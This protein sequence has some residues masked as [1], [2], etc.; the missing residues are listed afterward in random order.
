MTRLYLE[1]S[2]RSHHPLVDLTDVNLNDYGFY[3]PAGI[4]VRSPL[5]PGRRTDFI[6]FIQKAE[7]FVIPPSQSLVIQNYPRGINWICADPF[8]GRMIGV[9]IDANRRKKTI[10]IENTGGRSVYIDGS[11]QPDNIPY[12]LDRKDVRPIRRIHNAAVVSATVLGLDIVKANLNMSHL[13]AFASRL[14]RS[15]A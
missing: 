10:A 8:V 7:E 3:L 9:W 15:E 12:I 1:T 14:Q 2:P 4:G 11:L 6:R 5:R 13:F